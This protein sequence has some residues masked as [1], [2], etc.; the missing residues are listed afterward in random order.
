[1]LE[2]SPNVLLRMA[3][4][5]ERSECRNRSSLPSAHAPCE[6]QRRCGVLEEFGDCGKVKEEYL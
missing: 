3:L 6:A 2:S 1:V 5:R 4:D